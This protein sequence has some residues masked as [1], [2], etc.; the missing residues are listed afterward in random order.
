VPMWSM[1]E[2]TTEEQA[3]KNRGRSNYGKIVEVEDTSPSDDVWDV[4]VGLA[5]S[6]VVYDTT[7]PNK[8]ASSTSKCSHGGHDRCICGVD[9][10]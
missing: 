8:S 5:G 6:G 1:H 9:G 3:R 10:A 7:R 4:A 2:R